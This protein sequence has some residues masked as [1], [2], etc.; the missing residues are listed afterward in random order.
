LRLAARVAHHAALERREGGLDVGEQGL[1][2]VAGWTKSGVKNRKL[3][4]RSLCTFSAIRHR[5]RT[6][7]AWGVT[8]SPARRSRASAA[9]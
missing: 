5:L 1:A 9:V 3:W 4:R 8:G 2:G 7:V 6:S